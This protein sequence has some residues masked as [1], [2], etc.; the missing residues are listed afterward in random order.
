MS[1][2]F[3]ENRSVKRTD[4][5][6]I[7]SCGYFQKVLY[8]YAIFSNDTD[9]VS[10]CLIIPWLFHIQGT[11]FSEAVCGEK[12]FFCAVISNHNFRPVNHRCKYKSQVMF[13]KGEGSAVIYSDLLAFQIQVKEILHHAEGFFVGNNG[14][15]RINFHEV[16]DIG[17]VV[18]F[19]MLCDQII[20]FP[21][22]Q[23]LLNVIQPFVGKI[24]IYGIHNRNFFVQDHI[25][26]VGHAVW[27][28][29]LA[30]KKVNLMIINAYI[31]D[32]ICDFHEQFLFSF[33][34]GF[35][36]VTV[37]CLFLNF[38]KNITDYADKNCCKYNKTGKFSRLYIFSVLL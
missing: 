10:S 11:E 22:T 7:Q 24:C 20:R 14:G 23:N 35:I 9:K 8:L 19:H 15:V 1:K 4:G 27:H 5:L 31:F 12:D 32:G 37:F 21:V 33:Y 30:F 38:D 2:I 29:V 36:Y 16:G 26:V 34:G 13:S 25:G 28:F 3:G 18:R 6:D 17:C